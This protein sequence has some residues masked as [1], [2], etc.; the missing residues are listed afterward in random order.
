[1]TEVA[2]SP[3]QSPRPSSSSPSAPQSSQAAGI[4]RKCGAKAGDFFNAWHRITSSY[5]L[6]AL[7]GSYSSLL[8]AAGDRKKASI[9]TELNGW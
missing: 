2:E 4:C 1:M 6:P 3:L 5:F 9:G 7:V 8:R